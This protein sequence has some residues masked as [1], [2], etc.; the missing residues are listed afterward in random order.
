MSKDTKDWLA[1]MRANFFGRVRD[2]KLKDLVKFL[3]R[4]PKRAPIEGDER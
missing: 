2:S 3:R 1:T 4:A